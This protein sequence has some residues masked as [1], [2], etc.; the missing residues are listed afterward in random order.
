MF[1]GYSL[2]VEIRNWDEVGKAGNLEKM[3]GERRW[4]ED[5]PAG[6]ECPPLAKN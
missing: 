6:E 4:R 3:S 5:S 1:A 2:K